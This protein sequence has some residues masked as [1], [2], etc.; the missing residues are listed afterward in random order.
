[1][2]S[3]CA[4]SVGAD[5]MFP[6]E[7]KGFELYKKY[8]SGLKPLESTIDDVRKRMGHPIKRKTKVF[9]LSYIKDDWNIIVRICHD[10]NYYLDRFTGNI[11][12]AIDFIP[13]KKISLSEKMFSKSFNKRRVICEI[14]WD[15][16]YDSYGLVYAVL[17]NGNLSRISYRAAP[18]K[19]MNWQDWKIRQL[20]DEIK[21]L[22]QNTKIEK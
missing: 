19:I 5:E 15:E 10:N 17:P 7:L 1:M 2:M 16:F 20:N 4:Y 3:F 11:I 8:A 12:E 13:L 14:K 9:F 18:D 6:N 22:K 21:K